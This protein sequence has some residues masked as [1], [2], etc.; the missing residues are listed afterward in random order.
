M[1]MQASTS[2]RR[3]AA[4]VLLCAAIVAAVA[5]ALIGLTGGTAIGPLVLRSPIRPL[6]VAIALLVA[7]WATAGAGLLSLVTM[8]AH[9]RR[10]AASAAAATAGAVL[11]CALAWNTRAA[12]GSDSSCYVLQAEAFAHGHAELANPV[13]RVL[14]DE[15]NAV[16]APTGF[17]PAREYGEAVP[18]CPPGLSLAMAAASLVHPS[19]VFLVVPV[20]AALT[21]WLTFLYGRRLDGDSTGAWAA[22]LVAASPIFL[23][24]AVQPMSDVPAAAAWM[25]A[26][27][28]ASPLAAGGWASVAVLVRPNLLLLVPLLALTEGI[29]GA[30]FAAVTRRSWRLLAGLLPGVLLLL[31]LNAVRYGAPLATGYG[32]TDA[33]FS[34]AHVYPNLLR[35]PRWLLETHTPFLLLSVA[36]PFVLRRDSA[37]ARLAWISLAAAGLL[38]ATYLAYTVFDD[39][40]YIRFLLPALPMLL[41]LSVATLRATARA[42]PARVAGMAAPILCGALAIAFVRVGVA[43]HVTQLPRLEARFRLT[44]EFAARALPS[45][46]VV[47]AVQQ[48]G[49]V[50]VHGGRDTIAWDAIGA[51]DLDGTIARLERRGRLVF[52]ALEDGEEPRFRERFLGERFGALEWPPTAVIEAA[53]RVRVFDVRDRARFLLGERIETALVR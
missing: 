45:A 21:V 10:A 39:W 6:V 53:V 5:A 30:S 7:S 46:A 43:R 28:S 3:N 52:L 44:G 11:V 27:V 40:W 33:L 37:R 34:R 18:I 14:P 29:G 19:A 51:H 12:G 4:T 15:P 13:A 24:Q 36:G 38:V 17:L 35:Y 47:I 23:Y 42:L 26:L 41:A 32:S 9:S 31:A 50:R 16:F 8:L 1:T 2:G 20:T 22:V 25:A 49:S 48:S